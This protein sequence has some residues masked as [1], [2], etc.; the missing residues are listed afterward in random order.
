MVEC[1]RDLAPGVV[2]FSML[3]IVKSMRMDVPQIA[4]APQILTKTCMKKMFLCIPFLI[5]CR[6]TLKI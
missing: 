5:V 1:L 2:N 6:Y 3:K 4:A